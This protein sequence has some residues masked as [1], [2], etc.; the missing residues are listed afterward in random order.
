MS[1][2]QCKYT[3]NSSNLKQTTFDLNNL[4]KHYYKSTSELKNNKIFSS[5]ELIESTKKAIKGELDKRDKIIN[6]DNK[7]LVLDFISSNNL[8][9]YETIVGLKGQSRLVPEYTKENR[10]LNFIKLELEKLSIP[11][12]PSDTIEQLQNKYPDQVT[13]LLN[14][15]NEDIKVDE[16]TKDLGSYVHGA[17]NKLILNKG[18]FDENIS[19]YLKEGIENNVSYL[20]GDVNIWVDKI[21]N[22]LLDIYEDL[23]SKGF[24]LSNVWLNSEDSAPAQVKGLLDIVLIDD[25]GNAHIYDL[26]LSKNYYQDWDSAKK[27]RADWELSFYRALLGQYIDVKNLSLNIIPIVVGGVNEESKIDIKNLKLDRIRNR[28]ADPDGKHLLFTS[29]RELKDTFV[30]N[31]LTSSKLYLTSRAL[32]PDNKKMDYNP[33]RK[34]DLFNDLKVIFPEYNTKV[35]KKE[36]NLEKLVSSALKNKGFYLKEYDDFRHE[37]TE[38]TKNGKMYVIPR[39]GDRYKTNKEL[40]DDYRKVIAKYIS[41]VEKGQEEYI[42]NLRNKISSALKS[43]NTNSIIFKSDW[44][45]IFI[46]KILSNYIHGDYKVVQNSE[47]MDSLGIILLE[48]TRKNSYVILDITAYNQNRNYSPDILYKDVEIIKSFLFFNHFYNELNLDLNTIQDIVIINTDDL[49][50]PPFD[51]ETVFDKYSD[52]MIKK[53]IKNRLRKN[54]NIM[55]LEDKTEIE[56]REMQR[57]TFSHVSK[58]DQENLNEIFSNYTDSFTQLPI[59]RLK[60]LIKK[61]INKYPYLKNRSF[62]S[63][64]DFNNNIEKLFTYL[65]IL[66]LVKSGIVPLGDFEGL[67]DFNVKFSNAT[68]ILS[69]LFSKNQA[70]YDQFDKKMGSIIEGFKTNTP[71]KMKSKDLQNMNKLMSGTN[72][73]IGRKFN[74]EST[75]ISNH[76][77]EYYKKI[78][79][80]N[81]SQNFIGN[82]RKKF[83]NM[84]LKDSK[85]NISSEWKMK[86]PYK[87]D[88]DNAMTDSE[89]EYLKNILFIKWKYTTKVPE[90]KI[91]NIDISSLESIRKSGIEDLLRS[92]DS[93]E[94]FEMP[95]MRSQQIDRYGKYMF[96]G[97]DGV[98]STFKKVWENLYNIIDPRE[99]TTEEQKEIKK[100]LGYYELYDIYGN[101]SRSFIQS[102][103]EIDSPGYYEIDLD[104]ILHRFVFSKIRKKYV[105]NIMPIIHAYSSWIKL[106]GGKQNKDLSKLL[107][108]VA[109]R[110]KISLFD[111]PIVAEEAEDIVK[112]ANLMK[113]ATTPAMLAFRPTLLVKELTLGLYKAYAL[114]ATKIYGKEEFGMSEITQAITKLATMKKTFS[115]EWSLIELMNKEYRIAN[116]DITTLNKKFQTN[117]R[118]FMMG[119]GKWMYST[120]TIGDFYNRMALFIAKSIK[121]GSY[122]AHSISN[123]KLIYDPKKDKRFEYYLKNR[124]KYKNEKG[125]YIPATN[126]KKYN[127]QRNLYML[128][129]DEI[130]NDLKIQGDNTLSEEDMLPQAYSEK[131]RESFK[132]FSDTIYGYY[133]KD[134]QAEWH[135]TWYGIIYLQFLQWWPGKISLWFGSQYKED[136]SIRGHHK[137]KTIK[138]DG[139]EIPIWRKVYYNED[140]DMEFEEVEEDTGDPLMIWQGSPQE[141]LAYSILLTIRDIAKFDWSNIKDNEWRTRQ[142]LYGL[143]DGF[144]MMLIFKLLKKLYDGFID[145][146][147]TEGLSGETIRFMSSVNSKVL[148][149]ANLWDNTFGALRSTPAFWSYTTKVVGDMN[150]VFKGDKDFKNII[151]SDFRMFEFIEVD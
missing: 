17:L 63:E 44:E 53:G 48:N 145:E 55:S 8:D 95:L 66:L 144:L 93:E 23:S 129:M 45:N 62:T 22:I 13:R 69:A 21:G 138:K 85:G 108:N 7:F 92:I 116:M 59:Y 49:Q 6:N 1:I 72:N 115:L 133:D 150:D 73:H 78:N 111:E 146:N 130:N 58:E 70:E 65:Q 87:N 5:D 114:G 33:E 10:I 40:E 134:S 103:V 149:E 109:N 11:T 142:A 54:I 75:V 56:L 2:K 38:I 71:E 27:L 89:R 29:V 74:E 124:D 36:L 26:K 28:T 118:G 100:Q 125:Q 119:F 67:S 79:Y 9:L 81:V 76:T 104:A 128:I 96:Q 32:I 16:N 126:D 98:R 25:E 4:V 86:N 123:G 20:E 60:E 135:N 18:N 143:A 19:S 132:S 137:Q 120:S 105:D 90:D 141:G 57:Y 91:K 139:K 80:N 110:V 97:V 94:Y 31:K 131:E 50:S 113:T 24:V 41:F 61:F 12:L 68:N 121:D 117:R 3:I 77:K 151:S 15:V 106:K 99:L 34:T 136:L 52:L 46:N 42:H 127:E 88:V 147:G 39:V 14:E 51:M 107:E 37:D 102:K 140:G 64:L 101:Q 82:H 84:W 122:D 30:E 43:G 112:V 83:E 148:N 47:E 35:V